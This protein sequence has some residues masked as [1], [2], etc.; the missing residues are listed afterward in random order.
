M[1]HHIAVIGGGASGL[2][3][4]IFAAAKA[5]VVVYERLPRV[6]K[7]LL[8]TGNGR[9]NLSNASEALSEHLHGDRGFIGAVLASFGRERTLAFF[10]EIGVPTRQGDEGKLYPYSLQASAVLDALRFEA[11]ARGA[12]FRVDTEIT[13]IRAKGQNFLLNEKLYAERVIIA[14]GGAASPALGGGNA[15]HMLLRALG[16]RLTPLYPSIVQL[17]TDAAQTRSLEG[18]KLEGRLTLLGVKGTIARAEGELLFTSYGLSGPPALQISREASVRLG[19]EE[20]RVS[21]DFLQLLEEDKL[22]ELLAERAGRHKERAIEALFL[23][24]LPARAGLLLCKAADLPLKA[25]QS[26]L[27]RADAVRLAALTKAFTVAVTGT[28]GFADAQATVGGAELGQFD[29]KTLESRVVRGLYACGEVLDVDGDCGGYN[30]QWAWS[31]GAV[32]GMSA[33]EGRE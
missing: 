33:A 13:S 1:N 11:A 30:L 15:G 26:A 9:C 32:A 24:L 12:E 10:D 6:G 31:S 25:P 29:A 7:K 18:I 5:N 19:K 2:T 4:A 3:A 27:T 8:A 22:A 17:K 21:I 20:L 14:A 16:H 23:G 28:R